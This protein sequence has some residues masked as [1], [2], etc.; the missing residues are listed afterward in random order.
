MATGRDLRVGDH[1]RLRDGLAVVED[2]EASH[3]GEV[4]WIEPKPWE[5]GW[6]RVRVAF[7]NRTLQMFHYDF[8]LAN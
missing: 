6:H 5:V 7:P 3:T 1:V 2:V 4:V 8:V